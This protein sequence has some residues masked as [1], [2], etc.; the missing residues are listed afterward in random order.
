MLFS[1]VCVFMLCVGVGHN[2]DELYP[3]V[4]SL[5]IYDGYCSLFQ[6]NFYD[7][8]TRIC[9][10]YVGRRKGTVCI[11]SALQVRLVSSVWKTSKWPKVLE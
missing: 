6:N 9:S 1:H 8:R 11:P 5:A 2:T 10:I 4:F 7:Q 3:S